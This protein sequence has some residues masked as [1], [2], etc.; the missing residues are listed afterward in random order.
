MVWTSLIYIISIPRVTHTTVYSEH[1]RIV[2]TSLSDSANNQNCLPNRNSFDLRSF[3]FFYCNPC[4]SALVAI[5]IKDSAIVIYLYISRYLVT[6]SKLSSGKFNHIN[7][8]LFLIDFVET[9]A[10][11]NNSS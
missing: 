7:P 10:I 6:L 9:C 2:N 11:R 3:C 4:V 5:S 1:L 8:C